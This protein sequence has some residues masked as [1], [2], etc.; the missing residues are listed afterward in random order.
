MPN[1]SRPRGFNPIRHLSG[2]PWNGLTQQFLV[3]S[4]D[5][6]AVY[7]G[8]PVKIAGS[9]G[10]AGQIVAGVNVEG[11]AT[12]ARDES[13]TTGQTF[14]GVVVGFLVDPTNLQKAYRV[15]STSRVALVCTDP[16]VVYEVQEDGVTSNLAAGD[17]G[18]NTSITTTAGSTTTGLSGMLITSNSK[19]TTSTLPVKILGLVPRADNAFGLA[20]TDK[21]K[22]EVLFNTGIYAPNVAG[23]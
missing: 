12:I 4:G 21:A 8:D 11:M 3:D 9:A 18:L 1:V 16:T 6:T 7:V 19:N 2:A 14:V 5:A 10:V 22:F 13:G 17:V 23:A 15:A 20:S